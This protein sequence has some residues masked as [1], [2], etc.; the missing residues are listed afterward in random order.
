MRENKFTH[1]KIT[2]T[3]CDEDYGSLVPYVESKH[4]HIFEVYNE[5]DDSISLNRGNI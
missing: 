4:L 5:E 2:V 1:I 3:E